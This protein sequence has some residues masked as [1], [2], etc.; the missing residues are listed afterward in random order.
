MYR[1]WNLILRLC[2]AAALLA[3]GVVPIDLV[4]TLVVLS[5]AEFL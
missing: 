1:P 4:V 5:N 3:A 2:P